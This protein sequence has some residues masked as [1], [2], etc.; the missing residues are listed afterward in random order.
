MRL[1]RDG[2]DGGEMADKSGRKV[3]HLAGK[4]ADA[5]KHNGGRLAN[6]G[7]VEVSIKGGLD[8]LGRFRVGVRR[9]GVQLDGIG[10]GF[11]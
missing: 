5:T 8:L 7:I 9:V 11:R 10:T 1:A 4:G 3:L 2:Q 6:L